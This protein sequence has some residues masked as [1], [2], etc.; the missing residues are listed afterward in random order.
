MGPLWPEAGTD[1]AAT[2]ECLR[3]AQKVNGALQPGERAATNASASELVSDV[4]RIGV[5]VLDQNNL[6]GKVRVIHQP[7]YPRWWHD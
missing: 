1:Y 2:G 3:R 4:K 5:G 7:A 6:C